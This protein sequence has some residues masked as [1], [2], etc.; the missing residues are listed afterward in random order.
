MPQKIRISSNNQTIVIYIILTVAIL[1]IFWQ[2]NHFTFINVDDDVCVT[3]NHHVQ[4]A[5][6]PGNFLWAFTTLYQGYWHPLTWLSF[7][8][9]YQLYGAD[10]GGYH[11]T[12][13]ILHVLSTLLLFWV[14]N[15]MTGAVWKSAFVAAFFGLHP[16][17][18]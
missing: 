14:F 7:M 5:M 8:I 15:R 16:L 3:D 12:N 2:V 4:S 6:I 18:V 13:V 11:V 1:A 17:R 9:D 10:A